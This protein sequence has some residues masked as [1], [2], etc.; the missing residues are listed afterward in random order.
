MA[1]CVRGNFVTSLVLCFNDLTVS[2]SFHR[3]VGDWD[4]ATIGVFKSRHR[5]VDDL[6]RVIVGLL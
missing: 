5:L 3:E 2:L 4:V 6:G 1:H